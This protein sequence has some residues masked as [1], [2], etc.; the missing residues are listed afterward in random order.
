[1]SEHDHVP[2]RDNPEV[3]HE[4]SD[5]NIQL[6]LVFGGALLAVA[7]VVHIALYGL[8][9]Y[10]NR[11]AGRAPAAAS[12]PAPLDEPPPEP[13][14]QVAPRADLARM[15]AAEEKEL[16]TYGWVDR[17]KQ[18]V[19]IPIDRAM[20]LLAERGLPARKDAGG[21]KAGGQL[22]GESR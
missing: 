5:V 6:V 12:A 1:M 7:L 10:Y 21:V 3:A 14:L 17:D 13:R 9:E 19:R 11:G 15:R 18:V 8:L 2:P 20:Q 22:Q 16:E 4:R